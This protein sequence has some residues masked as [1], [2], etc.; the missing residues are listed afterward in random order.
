MR[1]ITSLVCLLATL[2]AAP[3][4]A[5][6]TGNLPEC[7]AGLVP[8]PPCVAGASIGL[9]CDRAHKSAAECFLV[10]GRLTFGNGTPAYRIWPVG[11]TRMLGILDARGNAES[12]NVIPSKILAHLRPQ[13]NPDALWGDFTVCPMAQKRSGWMQM[14][15]IQDAAHV[16]DRGP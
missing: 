6:E 4:A 13:P 3:R 16:E 7:H 9:K 2:V 14:V 8:P 11:S 10:H 12:D 1:P 5:P 15:C